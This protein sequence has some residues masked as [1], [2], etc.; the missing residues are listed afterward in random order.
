M[1]LL[2]DACCIPKVFDQKNSCHADYEPILD[3]ITHGDG[4][5]V[6]G[7][8]KYGT[9]LRELAKYLRIISELQRKGRAFVLP[10]SDVD[11]IANGLRA[12]IA[13][14]EFNDEHLV[15]I[16]IV[17]R[18]CV[19]CTEDTTAISY[20][21]RRAFYL[22]HGMKKPKIYHSHRNRNLCCRRNVTENY[23]H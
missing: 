17:S 8:T 2:I 15:A 21:K 7:G 19:V 18:C 6:Y 10:Q 23:G 22:N 14:P 20:L 11:T 12:Q 1:C 4:R 5:M 9:E 16:V 13:D 3:W